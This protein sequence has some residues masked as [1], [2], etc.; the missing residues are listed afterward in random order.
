MKVSWKHSDML[1]TANRFAN[2]HSTSPFTE[3]DEKSE[4]EVQ[5]MLFGVAGLLPSQRENPL[6]TEVANDPSIV[7]LEKTLARFSI[8]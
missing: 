6:P 8:R 4:L 7:T 3:F 2:W 5:A 1:T